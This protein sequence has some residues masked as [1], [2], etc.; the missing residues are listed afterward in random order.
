MDN[1]GLEPHEVF[2]ISP[3]VV[4]S[5]DVDDSQELHVLMSSKVC[6]AYG[7]VRDDTGFRKAPTLVARHGDDVAPD[8]RNRQLD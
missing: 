6:E 5:F 2:A 8:S 3:G 1:S 7:L 4:Q